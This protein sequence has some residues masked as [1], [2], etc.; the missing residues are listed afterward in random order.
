MYVLH[1]SS[2]AVAVYEISAVGC[3]YRCERQ[4]LCLVFSLITVISRC[5]FRS[6]ALT[7]CTVLKEEY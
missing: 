7:T 4:I 2:Y 5:Y 1:I 6:M 3:E